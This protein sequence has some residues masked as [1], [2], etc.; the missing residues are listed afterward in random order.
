MLDLS[1]E[2]QGLAIEVWPREPRIGDRIHVAFRAPPHVGAASRRRYEVTV[3]DHR[4][5]RVATLL[6]GPGFVMRGVICVEWDGTDDRGAQVAPG[7]Y[8]LRVEGRGPSLILER[9]LRIEG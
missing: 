2:R 8:Q 3:L 5:R 7:G 9:T 1:P 4:R 6:R